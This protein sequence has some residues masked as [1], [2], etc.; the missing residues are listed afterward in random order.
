MISCN[1]RYGFLVKYEVKSIYLVVGIEFISGYF[2]VKEMGLWL[3]LEGGGS[4][5]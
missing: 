1:I 5:I 3:C 2:N 4:C